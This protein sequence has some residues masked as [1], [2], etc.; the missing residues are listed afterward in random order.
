MTVSAKPGLGEYL[1]GVLT[2]IAP[3]RPFQLALLDAVDSALA[4]PTE[5]PSPMPTY[6][7]ATITGYAVA[8]EEIAQATPGSPLLLSVIGEIGV[9]SWHPVRLPRKGC[10][11]IVAGAPLP[12]GAD[13]VI[14][15][16]WTDKGRVRVKVR[17]S[18]PP[19]FNVNKAGSQ[20]AAGDK[21][22]DTGEI[23]TAALVG[24]LAM[25]GFAHVLA[26]PRPRVITLGIGDELADAGVPSTPGR[27]VD[28]SSYVITAAARQSFAQAYRLDTIGEEPQRLKNTLDDNAMRADVLVLTG[29]HLTDALTPVFP[30]VKFHEIPVYPGGLIGYGRIGLDPTPVVCLPGNAGAAYVGFELLVRPIIRRLA[31]MDPVFR[32][33]VRATLTEPLTSMADVREFR[34]GILRQRRGGGYTVTPERG[35]DQLLQGLSASN[36]LMVL[37]EQ[38]TMAA[39]GTVVDVLQLDR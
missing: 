29:I 14:P 33:S 17:K 27:V 18:A 15:P 7:T 11:A 36:G 25:A 23:V 20:H 21:L 13:A 2:D 10:F 8:S 16:D 5:A 28:S 31:G 35:G 9:T 12:A 30:E 38:L 1:T 6:D 3:L 4:A 19:G 32:P 24:Q 39:A 26:R 37:G 34:P 22:A